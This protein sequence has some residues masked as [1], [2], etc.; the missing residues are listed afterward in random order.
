MKNKKGRI[1]MKRYKKDRN[2]TLIELLVVI[3]I[4]AILASMLLPALGKAREKAKVIS[5]A[6]NLKQWG[7]AHQ[8]YS[9][10]Y[11]NYFIDLSYQHFV[12]KG[13][14]SDVKYPN[15]ITKSAASALSTYAKND[16]LF[17]CPKID[18]GYHYSLYS[19]SDTGS[20]YVGYFF[21]LGGRSHSQTTVFGLEDTDGYISHSLARNV[22]RIVDLDCTSWPIM[23][24]FYRTDSD[25]MMPHKN[26]SNNLFQDGH[27]NHYKTASLKLG[28][29][30][31]SR[32]HLWYL[33]E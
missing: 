13:V 26:G 16:K 8:M 2:F 31:N 23:A 25:T 3:A 17:M 14:G 12:A 4:I 6:S 21:I 20:T 5:C 9:N 33:P 22:N 11:N 28:A 19:I 10:D 18:Y 32:N 7:L 27:V 1:T 24:D 15:K 29:F 30:V